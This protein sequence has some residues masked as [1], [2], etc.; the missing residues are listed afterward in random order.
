[1][2]FVD[3]YNTGIKQKIQISE[4]AKPSWRGGQIYPRRPNLTTGGTTNQINPRS[5]FEV[6]SKWDQR[7]NRQT[8]TSKM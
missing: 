5:G 1:M 8:L 2:T 7:S 4:G 6:G 3:V